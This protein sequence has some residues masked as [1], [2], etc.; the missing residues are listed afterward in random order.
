MKIF[1]HNIWGNFSPKECVGNRNYLIKELI[2]EERPDF[3]CFQE[4]NPNT[5]RAGEI[6]ISKLLGDKYDEVSI[7]FSNVNFTPIFYDKNKFRVIDSS[8]VV[9]EGFNDW[10]SKSFTWGVF[11]EINTLKKVI[12]FSTHLWWEYKEQKDV[13]QR[14]ENVVQ[15][16][17][18]VNKLYLKYQAP[19]IVAGDFNSGLNTKQGPEAYYEM[20]KNNMHDVRD[21][22]ND[23]DDY[24]T[25]A[26]VYPLHT[27]DGIY[28]AGS[29]PSLTIDYIFINKP[30]LVN[31]FKFNIIKSQKA[32]D[33]SDH[34]P[35]IYEFDLL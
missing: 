15:L 33:S 30:S 13:I 2:E 16:M 22:S 26:S 23:T 3:C 14:I 28:Y 24:Q 12:V 29:V 9:Y 32:K 6:G 7:E 8:Y 5:S 21:I 10:N 20:K 4:C 31:S 17:E 11:E 18:V 34:L 27:E 19:I 25:C 35:L 1:S